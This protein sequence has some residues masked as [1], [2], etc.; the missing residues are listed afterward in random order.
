MKPYSYDLVFDTKSN[1][2]RGIENPLL[3]PKMYL[4]MYCLLHMYV[5]AGKFEFCRY[6]CTKSQRLCR[7]IQKIPYSV[8]AGTQYFLYLPVQLNDAEYSALT[9][10]RHRWMDC[11]ARHSVGRGKVSKYNNNENGKYTIR[12]RSPLTD[13]LR[14]TLHSQGTQSPISAGAM[15]VVGHEPRGS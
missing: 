15:A 5:R 14:E 9:Y 7:K 2:G 6:S 10:L 12:Q 1:A 13:R 3:L 11:A 8:F 4:T